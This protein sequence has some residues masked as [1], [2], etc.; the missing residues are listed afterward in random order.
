MNNSNNNV[1]N[2]NQSFGDHH[3]QNGSNSF[4]LAELIG[5]NE[6]NNENILGEDEEDMDLP[7]LENI[8]L[9]RAK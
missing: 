5:T 7:D 4:N 3:G 8:G 9:K 6:G 1:L 2:Q